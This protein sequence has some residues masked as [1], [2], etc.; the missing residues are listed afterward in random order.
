ML[1][2][3]VLVVTAALALSACGGA[4][5]GGSTTKPT[6]VT[7]V[8]TTV[9]VTP[10]TASVPLGA[11]TTLAADVRDQNGAALGGQSVSWSSSSTS[12][13][14]VN[15]SGVVTAVAVGT[16]T[17]TASVGGKSGS[18]TITVVPPP[19]ATVSLATIGTL[20][21]GTT[22][23]LSV[24]LKDQ[25]GTVLTGRTLTFASST[26]AVATVDAAGKIT[27]L[28][29]GTSAISAT[30]A[31]VSSSQT[32]TVVPSGTLIP[33]VTSASASTLASGTTVLFTGSGF[34]ATPSNNT[35]T[36]RGV[37]ATVIAASATQLSVTIPCMTSGAASVQVT[38]KSLTGPAFSSNVANA[39]RSIPLGQALVIPDAGCNEIPAATGARY[40]I[41]VF[42]TAGS[43]N[44]LTDFEITGNP[45][46]VAA[47]IATPRTN[48]QQAL[49]T[50]DRARERDH[51][52]MLERNRAIIDEGRRLS[53]ALPPRT[54]S[55]AR[56]P[57]PA[58]G[59]VRDYFYTFTGGCN[60]TTFRMHTKVIYVGTKGVIYED[61]LNTIR[62][63]T[64]AALAGYYD[65][66]GRLFDQD[67]Y[68]V[69]KDNFG[70]PLLR[71]AVTDN[72]GRVS[73]VFSERLN[74]TGAAAFV[75]GCD[76]YP[77]TVF[78]GSN[79]GQVFYST[80]PTSAAL[81]PTST[82]SPDGWYSFIGRTVVH[83]LKH[84]AALSAR[85][86]SGFTSEESWLEEGTARQA[87]EL[88]A[89]NYFENTAWKSDKGY[90]TAADGGLFCDFHPENATCNGLDALRRPSWGM[91]RQFSEL[92][93]KLQE[94]WN[95]S[96][97]GDGTG[98]TGST[99]YN[100]VW[101]LLRFG[102][103][104]YGTNEATFFKAITSATTSGLT[105]LTAVTGTSADNL[106]GLWTLALYADNYPGLASPSA[107]I[108]IPT[109]NFRSIYASLNT[110]ATWASRFTTPFPI[111]SV[112][113]PYG[114]FASQ[115]TGLRGGANVY[116]EL[117]GTA[118]AQVLNIHAIGGGAANPALRVAIARLQ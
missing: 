5:D 65:R 35:V 90:G 23:Q 105:N 39:Q 17:I 91:R 24:T 12:V 57:L 16:S 20:Q 46:G 55:L 99:F 108:Q 100:T 2:Y 29:A 21:A 66:L 114:T 74:N 115:R 101:S 86:A 67:H 30:S 111:T 85:T 32:L 103:D 83:E 41:S 73:M 56:A 19:V 88:W 110:D 79:F 78:K 48:V 10:S 18:A 15:G 9:S 53:D 64:N 104:R 31:G 106:V 87:E 6:T 77:T 118:V 58:I 37:S 96:I 36:V 109:W 69:V 40:V 26:P 102:V 60:D 27:A 76:Q 95:Y 51:F 89:R 43:Q 11:S 3:P 33:T 70:D 112:Q 59:D 113:L 80:V 14:T 8:V 68:N 84:I 1:R 49:S 28:A 116:Y 92:L 71:D 13:T 44:T 62:S 38:S 42:T 63:T 47:L 75:S 61:T 94:P 93:P 45:G 4:T 34:D 50:A 97:F 81:S 82:A 52:L 7:P 117:S 72:D 107:D 54:A 98:Q 25:S 22:A